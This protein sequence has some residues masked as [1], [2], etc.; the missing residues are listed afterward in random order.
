[1]SVIY[2]LIVI[3]TYAG[4]FGFTQE[5]TSLERCQQAKQQLMYT[6]GRSNLTHIICVQK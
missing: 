6:I 1:M 3:G 2:I 5:F 4:G